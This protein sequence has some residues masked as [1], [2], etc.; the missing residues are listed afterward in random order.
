M[1]GKLGE[2]RQTSLADQAYERLREAIALGEL[3]PGMRVTERGLATALAVSATPVREALHRL[4]H[5]GLV[6]RSGPRTL[7][8]AEG[9]APTPT[10]QAEVESALRGLVA[11]YAAERATDEQ[12]DTLDAILDE[13]D[14]LVVRLLQRRE[15]GRPI[16]DLVEALLGKLRTFDAELEHACGN[17]ALTRLLPQVRTLDH[18]ERVRRTIDRLDDP[19]FRAHE[20]YGQHRQLVKALRAHDADTAE[21]LMVRHAQRAMAALT[22]EPAPRTQA[23]AQKSS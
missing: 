8:V 10:Q 13:A 3:A 5:D 16:D 17:P 9:P 20:R 14:D 4:E 1:V 15:D 12:L 19:A 18:H 6:Q 22:R 7:L 2:L 11:R 21:A 23:R